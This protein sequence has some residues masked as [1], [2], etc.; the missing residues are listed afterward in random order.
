MIAVISDLHLEEEASDVIAGNGR[1]IIFRRNLDPKAYRS[2]IAHM[3]DEV[4]RRKA[5]TF[6][7]VIAGDLFDFNR[8]TLWFADDVR[9]YAALNE[10]TPELEQ[11]LL[12]IVNAI[13]AEPPVAKT[14]ELFR[15]L[16]SGKYRP[17]N[18]RTEGAAFQ[19]FPCPVKITCLAGNH[20]R[21][22]NASLA[23]RNRIGKL[24][25]IDVA[26]PFPHYRLLAD[27]DVLIRHGHEYDNNNFGVDLPESGFIPLEVDESGYSLA[28]FGDFITIDVAVR[29]PHLFRR[30]YGDDQILKDKVLQALYLRLLQFDDVRPQSAL[31][32]YM[33]DVSSGDFSA[34]DAWKKLVPV[35]QD[36]LSEIH[37]DKFFRYWLG[38]RAK[39]WAP[40]E[41]EV[42]RGLLQLGGW[43]NRAA[44]EAARKIAHFMLGGE[45]DQP[46]LW[47]MREE[48][49]QHSQVRLVLAGHTHAPE[50]CLIRSD[51][52]GDRFYINTGTWR[53]V[54]PSTPDGRTFGRM[55]A[56][57]YVTVY[58]KSEHDDSCNSFDYWTGFTKDW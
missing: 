13:A 20:D 4:R 29:L 57:T 24:I 36:L 12:G 17:G 51:E 46:Q 9:P 56:L 28:N 47:A 11:K 49:I 23:I 19:D 8:T 52:S 50:V 40:A 41:L 27:P 5:K 34:E 30:K 3:A 33:L 38:R 22:A 15:D 58:S 54:I 37:D 7:L 6:E 42:A 2:F 31:L 21:V 16:A 1:Q 18:P 25:G 43:R 35:I 55:R 39:P 10:T 26:E 53:D 45:P 48:V 14:L 32:D 44:R